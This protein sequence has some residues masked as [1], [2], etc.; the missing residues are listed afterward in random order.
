MGKHRV[1][2]QPG[3]LSH[4]N[5]SFSSMANLALVL[6]LVISAQ[7]AMADDVQ[8][9]NEVILED[10]FESM[11]LMQ[12]QDLEIDNS[13]ARQISSGLPPGEYKL[14]IND[15]GYFTSPNFPSDYPNKAYNKWIFRCIGGTIRTSCFTRI[16]TSPG[17]KKDHLAMF[18]RKGFNDGTRYCGRNDRLIGEYP[19]RLKAVFKSNSNIVNKGFNCAYKCGFNII[20][21]TTA[22]TTTAATTTAAPT[23]TEEIAN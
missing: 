8:Q 16:R 15:A 22:A 18:T 13:R 4:S 1:L 12:H 23:T 11:I 10:D 9:L 2:V 14:S 6:L 21:T 3:Q 20:T 7:Q 5:S 17:C 19:N